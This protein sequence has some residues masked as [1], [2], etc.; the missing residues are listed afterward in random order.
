MAFRQPL[1]R[2]DPATQPTHGRVSASCGLGATVPV[3]TELRPRCPGASGLRRRGRGRLPFTL[4]RLL[5]FFV[6]AKFTQHQM[7]HFK[8]HDSVRFIRSQ[9][10][11]TSS[12]V[13]FLNTVLAPEGSPAPRRQLPLPGPGDRRPAVSADRAHGAAAAT[14]PCV[15]PLFTGPDA[16]GPRRCCSTRRT[17]PAWPRRPPTWVDQAPRVEYRSLREEKQPSS[18]RQ[19]GRLPA[20]L[21]R[22][23]R[24]LSGGPESPGRA[25]F[26]EAVRG[27]GP[28]P[29]THFLSQVLSCPRVPIR[30]ASPALQPPGQL[31]STGEEQ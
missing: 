10:C 17:P 16:G 22:H 28:A 25:V 7:N 21:Q 12:S 24:P 11:A 6:E 18:T 1:P 20:F 27:L 8:L 19:R 5:S 3:P 4:I 23:L 31:E 29:G 2:C 14:W 15:S 9:R 30:R 13:S 26:R